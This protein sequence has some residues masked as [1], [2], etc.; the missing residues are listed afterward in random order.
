MSGT[1]FGAD[2]ITDQPELVGESSQDRSNGPREP[3]RVAVE[4]ERQKRKQAT[5]E[6]TQWPPGPVRPGLACVKDSERT[7]FLSCSATRAYELWTTCRP[8]L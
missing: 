4:F 7:L 2:G 1:G 3:D 8:Y 6:R 5:P